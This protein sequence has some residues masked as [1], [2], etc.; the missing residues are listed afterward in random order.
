MYDQVKRVLGPYIQ[1]QKGKR[2]V[3]GTMGAPGAGTVHRLRDTNVSCILRACRSSNSRS[4]NLKITVS[5]R[6]N[7]RPKRKFGAL[8][9]IAPSG[10][11]I[12][13]Y[14]PITSRLSLGSTTHTTKRGSL[15]VVRI[16]SLLTT[17]NCIHNNYDPIN[18][19]GHCQALVSRAY[20]L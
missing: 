12:I 19:G 10:S 1:V 3:T 17:A 8:I 15:T 20:I 7:R 11:R 4:T 9:Y 18:V 16:G 5:R 2:T 13:Y 14:V 6:L